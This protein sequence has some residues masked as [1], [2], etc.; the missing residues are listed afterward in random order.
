[1]MQGADA[2]CWNSFIKHGFRVEST[3]G[4]RLLQAEHEWV[5]CFR[6]AVVLFVHPGLFRWKGWGHIFT[7]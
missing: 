6:T 1:V 2:L 4:G 3:S 7:T 5:W